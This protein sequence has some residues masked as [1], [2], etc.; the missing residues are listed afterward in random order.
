VLNQFIPQL[1]E[2]VLSDYKECTVPSAREPEV[3][4]TMAT[5]IEKLNKNFISYISGVFDAVFE[6]TLSMISENFEDFP[7]HRINYCIRLSNTAFPPS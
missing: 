2:L 7:E 1:L 5:I 3:L 4:S 6:C